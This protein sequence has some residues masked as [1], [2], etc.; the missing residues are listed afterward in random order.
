[1]LA[2][3]DCAIRAG[4]L[5]LGLLAPMLHGAVVGGRDTAKLA[6]RATAIGADRQASATQVIAILM[7]LATG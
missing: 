1:M 6:P 2:D 4:G 5:V 7:V 3:L